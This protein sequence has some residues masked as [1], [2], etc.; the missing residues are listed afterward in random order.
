M[1]V[2]DFAET[3]RK[4]TM[5][6]ATPIIANA[7]FIAAIPFLLSAIDVLQILFVELSYNVFAFIHFSG[8]LGGFLLRQIV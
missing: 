8:D 1:L 5:S 3:V 7:L 4:P 6:N 2:P